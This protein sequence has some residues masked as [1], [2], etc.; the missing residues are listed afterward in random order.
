MYLIENSA[1]R[2]N[3]KGVYILFIRNAKF[4]IKLK[5]NTVV[6]WVTKLSDLKCG[7]QHYTTTYGLIVRAGERIFLQNDATNQL[8]QM[9]LPFQVIVI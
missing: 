4:D 8:H 7:Y 2:E 6:L 3:C 5:A 1:V 9:S